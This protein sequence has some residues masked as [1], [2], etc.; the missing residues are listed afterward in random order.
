[1]LADGKPTSFS[2]VAYRMC[3]WSAFTYI[4]NLLLLH[5]VEVMCALGEDN[6]WCPLHHDNLMGVITWAAGHSQ[7]PLVGTVEGDVKHLPT[8]RA[9]TVSLIMSQVHWQ[10]DTVLQCGKYCCSHMLPCRRT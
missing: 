7:T 10:D 6:L 2:K 1:M 5:V 4:I 3:L 9:T 8:P